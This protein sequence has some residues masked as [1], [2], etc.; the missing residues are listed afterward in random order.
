[1]RPSGVLLA[2]VFGFLALAATVWIGRYDAKP[3]AILEKAADPYEGLPISETG[4]HPKAATDETEFNFGTMAVGNEGEHVFT[5]RNDGE[6]DLQLKKG[7]STCS[8]TVGELAN[9]SKIAPG[10]SVEIKLNWKIKAM[11]ETFRHSASVYTNDPERREL[12]F[13]VTG[14]VD[15]P[16]KLQPGT[17]EAGELSAG[18]AVVKGA[19]FSPIE[20]DFKIT[21][22]SS[23]QGWATVESTPMTAE[24]L[25]EYKA[26][27]GYILT[28]TITPTMPIGPFYEEVS[29]ETTLPNAATIGFRIN[30]TR[31]GP[32]EMFGPNFRPEANALILGEFPASAGK[33]A[34]IS[35]FARDLETDLEL[36]GADQ[37]FNSVKVELVKDEKLTGKAKRYFLKIQIPPGEPQDRMRKKSEKVNLK[38]NH[39][40]AQKVRLIV[41]FLAV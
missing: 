5:I 2:V 18:N 12:Q 36:L 38:F 13:T 11:T 8:C 34:T 30:G 3:P 9:D 37:E 39:P 40:D 27:S 41:E 31:P 4:P 25:K 20:A 16:Y 14:K 26:K 17:W 33:S 32:L 7:R 24:E 35:V 22:L 19:L 29:L 10:K 21:K 6:G 23:R 1:M 15:E 28:A